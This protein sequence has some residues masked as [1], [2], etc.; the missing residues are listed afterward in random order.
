[1]QK[2]PVSQNQPQS[3]SAWQN[4][5]KQE[6][7]RQLVKKAVIWGGIIIACIAVVAVLVKLAGT[8]GGPG[9]APVVN[10]K[11]P[12]VSS[13]D[14]I[15]G[16]PEA[17]VAV[18]EYSDF[19]CPACASYNPMVNAL[20]SEYD[21]KVKL[22]YRFFPLRGIHKN[23]VI[24]GRAGY[25][26]WKLGKFSEMKDM[27]FDNQAD[28]ENSTDPEKVFGEYAKS[29]DLNV[30]EFNKIMNSKE[31]EEAVVAGETEAMSLGLN[32]TPTFFIGNK[33]VS[34]RTVDDFKKLIDAE[35]ESQ[36]PLQ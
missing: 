10:E 15:L 5:I 11:L 2:K 25:A 30:D 34:P 21:G 24:S 3:S 35:L 32:S 4:N 28:W 12:A 14:I 7:R 22:A 8:S 23:G 18:I 33:Q 19:Q 16:N 20:L 13:K 36:K 1:M 17:K 6:E 31:A 9:S 27:L 26:A 29:L